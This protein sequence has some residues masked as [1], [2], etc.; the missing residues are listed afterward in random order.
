MVVQAKHREK[1]Y[2][3]GKKKSHLLLETYKKGPSCILFVFI[4][5]FEADSRADREAV[6][7]IHSGQTDELMP[8]P[9]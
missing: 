2:I 6:F 4:S 8:C 1:H 3:W 9:L 5:R 7:Q